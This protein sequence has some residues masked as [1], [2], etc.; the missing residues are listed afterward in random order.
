MA[1]PTT[2]VAV[3][4]LAVSSFGGWVKIWVDGRKSSKNGKATYSSVQDLKVMA[5]ANAEKLS[6]VCEKV[7]GQ[8]AMLSGFK[9]HCASVSGTLAEQVAEA[10]KQIYDHVSKHP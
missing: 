9:D 10:R 1:E 5:L 8:S 7:N 6:D 3:A 4:A 2:W